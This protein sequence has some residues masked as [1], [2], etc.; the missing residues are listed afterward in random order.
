MKKY[1]IIGAIL[2]LILIIN[3]FSCN[4]L[5][6]HNNKID[7]N[8]Q[9]NGQQVQ[10]ITYAYS[11]TQKVLHLSTCYHVDL[12]NQDYI[13]YYQGDIGQLLGQGYTLCRHCL[14]TDTPNDDD[15]EIV[16]ENQIPKED[17][18]FVINKSKLTI[19]MLDCYNID[20]MAAKN[21]LYTDLTLEE[22]LATEHI[23]CGNCLPDEYEAYKEAHPELFE[24]DEK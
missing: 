15:E 23:P 13:K 1:R 8:D 9:N 4:Q 21:I 2:S 14:V 17:A 19:H 18:T 6:F 24:K 12:M 20:R 7:Q 10:R 16:D 11:V 3:L 22:L 5:N